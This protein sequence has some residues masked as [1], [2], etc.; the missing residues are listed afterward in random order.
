MQ[1]ISKK[2][3]ARSFYFVK[4]ALIC[5]RCGGAMKII[6]IILDSEETTKIQK[7]LI[8]IHLLYLQLEFDKVEIGRAPPN[9]TIPGV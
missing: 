9:V 5:P 8:K 2:Y 1:N 7:H 4:T 3:S 6:A